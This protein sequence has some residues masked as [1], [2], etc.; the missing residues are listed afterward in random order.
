MGLKAEQAGKLIATS[1]VVGTIAHIGSS[2]DVHSHQ[3]E[4]PIEN[5]KHQEEN[6]ATFG[7]KGKQVYELQ[8]YLLAFGYYKGQHDGVFGLLTK[9]AV[10]EYQ[11]FNK[12]I[13]DGVAGANTYNHMRVSDQT[14]LKTVDKTIEEQPIIITEENDPSTAI[15]NDKQSETLLKGEEILATDILLRIGDKGSDV[16]LLQTK[17]QDLGYY[18]GI[19][20]IYGNATKQ[21]VI[22]YQTA[23]QLQVDG[24]AGPETIGHLQSEEEKIQY[25]HFIKTAAYDEATSSEEPSVQKGGDTGTSSVVSHAEKLLGSPYQWGGTSPSGFDCSGFLQYVFKQDGVNI[26]RTVQDI[27]N[28]A[29]SVENREIGDIVFFTTYRSGPS[30]AGIYLGNGQFIHSGSSTG[31]TISKLNESYWSSRYIGTKR[32]Q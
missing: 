9:N 28:A 19:D 23:H 11:T 30:H 15:I 32:I 14:V 2:V 10:R 27:W 16:K 20:G 5:E 25:E 4:S 1:V 18:S 12:L 24:I 31:V 6:H 22:K 26:P 8:A 13:V 17:L 21:A 29:S 7:D 3:M